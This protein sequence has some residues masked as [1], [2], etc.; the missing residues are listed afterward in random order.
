MSYSVCDY[1]IEQKQESNVSYYLDYKRHHVKPCTENTRRIRDIQQVFQDKG[2]HHYVFPLYVL[3]NIL[4]F[5]T[6]SKNSDMMCKL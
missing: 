5:M 1:V 4:T 6:S 2:R 3:F